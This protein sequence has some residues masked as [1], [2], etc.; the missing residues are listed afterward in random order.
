[1]EAFGPGEEGHISIYPTVDTPK[2][3][4]MQP[5]TQKADDHKP[6]LAAS[7]K[8]QQMIIPSFNDIFQDWARNTN[9]GMMSNPKKLKKL[10]MDDYALCGAGMYMNADFA[11]LCIM[12][13]LTAWLFFFDDKVDHKDGELFEDAGQFSALT[14]Q[15]LDYAA[16]TLGVND[17]YQEPEGG[18][19]DFVGLFHDVGQALR[20]A[21]C[22]G[23]V[24]MYT[25]CSATEYASGVRLPDTDV[26]PISEL[27]QLWAEI[28]DLMIFLTTT[29]YNLGPYVTG[30]GRVIV[31]I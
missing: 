16:Y 21:L 31:T 6:S 28:R 20:C 14:Q 9:S 23:T 25:I 12:T 17:D 18:I 2:P 22:E 24:C 10:E 7:L 15:A 13:F 29:R 3:I 26:L 1:M 27:V 8:G 5:L 11:P 30:D 19:D 4:L